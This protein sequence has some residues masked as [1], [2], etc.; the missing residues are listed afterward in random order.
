MEQSFQSEDASRRR[1]KVSNIRNVKRI[2]V[3]TTAIRVIWK[4]V[5][6]VASRCIAVAVSA[7]SV[8]PAGATASRLVTKESPVAADSA[9]AI[10]MATA[11]RNAVVTRA[12]D[13]TRHSLP[14]SDRLKR[15]PS[16]TPMTICAIVSRI[17]GT[18][19]GPKPKPETRA[20]I[21]A[22]TSSQ[23]LGSLKPPHQKCSGSSH[24]E[25]G[26]ERNRFA[27]KRYRREVDAAIL[28]KDRYQ[29]RN[30]RHDRCNADQM[31]HSDRITVR[32]LL[33]GDDGHLGKAGSGRSEEGG[34]AIGAGELL[35]HQRRDHRC[36]DHQDRCKQHERQQ[37]GDGNDHDRNKAQADSQAHR[38][39]AELPAIGQCS[40]WRAHDRRRC[41][42]PEA[43][44]ADRGAASRRF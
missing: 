23:V 10:P 19:K 8:T 14:S 1:E 9:K 5:T 20:P 3:I 12:E 41:R 43:G 17:D 37:L 27:P 33:V 11:S 24:D 36:N 29:E 13:V 28:A 18:A 22:G 32:V 44:R 2:V 26:N 6:V 15:Q 42:K 40:K 38:H 4:A 21:A 30:D 39:L 7:I 25:Q 34:L 16:Q 35:Q 31:D